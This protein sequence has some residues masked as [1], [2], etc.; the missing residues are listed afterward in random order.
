MRK[1]L[2]PPPQ[3]T[4]HLRYNCPHL[5]FG[6]TTSHLTSKWRG[7]FQYYFFFNVENS[8]KREMRKN[9]FSTKKNEHPPPRIF[10][11]PIFFFCN[12]GNSMKR[13]ENMKFWRKKILKILFFS[14]FKKFLKNS[15]NI[16]SISKT[17][18]HTP[19]LGA[20]TCKVSRKYSNAFLSYSAKTKRDG[21]TDGRGALQYLPSRAFGAAGDKKWHEACLGW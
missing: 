2:H 7:T 4:P 1:I 13:E 10:F 3:T 6:E 19:W 16:P 14:I 20:R 9:C 21:Q 17:I 12:V 8:I 5:L 11:T 15:N 18:Q